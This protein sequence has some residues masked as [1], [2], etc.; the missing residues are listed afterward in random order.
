[1]DELTNAL[2]QNLSLSKTMNIPLTELQ[3]TG[4]HWTKAWLVTIWHGDHLNP[5]HL[6]RSL[7][8]KWKLHKKVDIIRVSHNKYACKIYNKDE[9]K[10]IEDG[11]PWQVLNCL[12]LMEKYSPPTDPESVVFKRIPQWITFKGLLLQHFN[13]NTIRFIAS[14]V[15]YVR[16][17][18]PKK[19]RRNHRG[20]SLGSS[21]W[22]GHDQHNCNFQFEVDL[23]G[24]ALI[25]TLAEFNNDDEGEALQE[26]WPHHV[27]GPTHQL[28]GPTQQERDL[29][30]NADSLAQILQIVREV[31]QENN[32]LSDKQAFGVVGSWANNGLVSRSEAAIFSQTKPITPSPTITD[33]Y[34]THHLPFT[35][36]ITSSPKSKNE[37]FPKNPRQTALIIRENSDAETPTPRRRGRPLGARNKVSKSK[38]TASDKGKGKMVIEEV[39]ETRKS[40]KKRKIEEI[41]GMESEMVSYIPESTISNVPPLIGFQE[42]LVASDQ[43]ALDIVMNLLVR[44]SIANLLVSHGLMSPDI[45]HFIPSEPQQLT[46]PSPISAHPGPAHPGPFFNETEGY[47]TRD[48]FG[49]TEVRGSHSNADQNSNGLLYCNLLTSASDCSNK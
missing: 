40:K 3:A 14:A 18:L 22:V 49:G 37:Q 23:I 38:L 42:S 36:P 45:L 28:F 33:Q 39:E 16:Q 20:A 21:P 2:S 47:I 27:I 15:G 46:N 41:L 9:E 19:Q 12:I 4:A 24:P 35:S 30:L 44:P 31:I 25:E 17:V 48:N 32:S 11:Q 34:S 43:E 26:P 8:T 7:L 29:G 5:N 10:R 13:V 1:M 6:I